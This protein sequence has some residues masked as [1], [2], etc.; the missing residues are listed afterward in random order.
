VFG[1]DHEATLAAA[2]YVSVETI[3]MLS[4]STP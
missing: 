2:G 4:G 1:P 3:A